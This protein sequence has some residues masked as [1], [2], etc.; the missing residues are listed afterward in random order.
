M[1]YFEA[2]KD[3]A[4]QNELLAIE[5]LGEVRGVIKKT[6]E[7]ICALLSYLGVCNLKPEEVKEYIEELVGDLCQGE[8]RK[9]LDTAGESL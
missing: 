2:P 3:D 7:D 6:S 8:L 4:S 9:L 5:K 1:T